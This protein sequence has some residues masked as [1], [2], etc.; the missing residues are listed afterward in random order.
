MPMHA[1]AQRLLRGWIVG[2]VATTVAAV[3]HSLAGGYEPGIL[4]FGVALVFAGL[5]GTAVIG[6][7]PSLPRLTVAVGAAQLAFHLVFSLLGSGGAE[8]T[9]RAGLSGM[10]GMS[11]MSGMDGTTATIP[12]PAPAMAMSGTAHLVDPGMWGAHAVAAVVTI[13][14]LRRAELAVWWML[15]RLGRLVIARVVSTPT[16][17]VSAARPRAL[18]GILHVRPLVSRVLVA[19]AQRRGPPL[20]AF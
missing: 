12:G 17:V 13:L 18:A 3:S 7:R 20:P 16:P 9:S 4:S 11:G 8:V 19:S 2:L 1:R 15:T 6:R 14:F 5:L 10:D